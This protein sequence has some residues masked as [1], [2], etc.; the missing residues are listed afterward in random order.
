MSLSTQKSKTRGAL[1]ECKCECG[2]KKLFPSNAL[3]SG[4]SKSCGSIKNHPRPA[5][6]YYEIPAAYL[7][8]VRQNA[9]KRNLLYRITSAFVW[10]LFLLQNRLC[11]MSRVRLSFNDG[12]RGTQGFTA[13]LDRI[14]SNKGYIKGNVRWVHKDLN[15]MRW[16]LSDR[17]FLYWC[18]LCLQ[19]AKHNKTW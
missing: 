7:N 19:T 4:N 2:N 3:T 14:D 6:R 5:I 10:K 16:K 17:E 18:S 12:N 1:W 11:A 15:R 8:A 9:I 13:S